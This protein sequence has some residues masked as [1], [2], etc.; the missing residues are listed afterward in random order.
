MYEWHKSYIIK[1]V[2]P[3][4]SIDTDVEWRF[5]HTRGW[6]F[7]YKLHLIS[8]T[9]SLIVPLSADYTRANVPD[10]QIYLR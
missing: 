6:I 10:N 3:R 8:S 4:S 5:S 9:G 2:V 7:G 1:G